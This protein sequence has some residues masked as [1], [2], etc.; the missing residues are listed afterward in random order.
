MSMMGV[1]IANFDVPVC[2]SFSNVILFDQLC[3]EIDVNRFSGSFSVKSLK[4]GLTFL[5]DLNEDR[6][7]QWFPS[8]SLEKITEGM[9]NNISPQPLH[10]IIVSPLVQ[11]PLLGT[12]VF[13]GTWG[14]GL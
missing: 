4:E 9:K 5:V 10:S 1:K 2:N 14:L 12:L 3:Y 6:Q 13:L 11:I 7:F 8:P